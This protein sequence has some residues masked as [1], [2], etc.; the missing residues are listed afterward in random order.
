M[1]SR[2]L[3]VLPNLFTITSIAFGIYSIIVATGARDGSDMMRAA[4]AIIFGIFCDMVDGRVARLTKTQ[5]DFGV[6]LDSLADLVTFGVAPS[7]LLY[8]WGLSDLGIVGMGAAILFTVCGALR[9]ARFNVM[10][11]RH[12]GVMKFFTGLPIPAAA[13]FAASLVLMIAS[14]GDNATLQPLNVLALVVV[15]SYLMISNI[16]YRTFK[17]LKPGPVTA[18]FGLFVLFI[19]G[20][21]AM[22]VNVPVMLFG[23]GSAYVALGLVE[24]V[25]FYRRRRLAE[26]A[27][28]EEE[29]EEYV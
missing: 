27:E 15:L 9:L 7:I 8:T 29:E 16:R 12:K 20:Y 18:A 11:N 26:R 14:F 25:I 4:V 28:E 17:D 23:L 3:Y 21:T 6:Q 13:G 19:A 22:K 5:S 24:E 2:M 10:A 1:R